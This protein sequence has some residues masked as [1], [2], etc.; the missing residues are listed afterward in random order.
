MAI[1]LNWEDA[2]LAGEATSLGT[3]DLELEIRILEFRVDN[4]ASLILVGF[5]L[6]S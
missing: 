5:C 4:L 6:E 2:G 3:D 1:P